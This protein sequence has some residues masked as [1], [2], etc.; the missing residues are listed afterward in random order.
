VTHL[1]A[2]R[3]H[4]N[5]HGSVPSC[6]PLATVPWGLR[7]DPVPFSGSEEVVD[8]DLVTRAVSDTL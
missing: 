8:R 1:S 2:P 7:G 3:M 5:K 4:V 6:L